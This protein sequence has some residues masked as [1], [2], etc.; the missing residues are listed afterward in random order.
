MYD[1]VIYNSTDNLR[2][3]I[4]QPGFKRNP[5]NLDGDWTNMED[6]S[7][8][9]AGREHPGPVMV[10]AS[11]PRYGVDIRQ[12]FVSWSKSALV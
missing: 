5:L 8:G 11:P 1:G 12:K 4:Q 9:T 3:A 7:P 10:L 2:A 6:Y